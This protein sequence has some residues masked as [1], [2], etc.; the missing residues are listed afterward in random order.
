MNTAEED[1]GLRMAHAITMVCVDLQSTECLGMTKFEWQL[2]TVLYC[3]QSRGLARFP[4][5]NPAIQS[6]PPR[7]RIRLNIEL[8]SHNCQNRRSNKFGRV[9]MPEA[10]N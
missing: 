5:M 2:I 1:R 10:G 8:E 7:P 9:P 6:N 4:S 3:T